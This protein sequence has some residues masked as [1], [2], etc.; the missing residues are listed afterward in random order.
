MGVIGFGDIGLEPVMAHDER[1]GAEFDARREEIER[2][3]R[4]A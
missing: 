2:V 1:A 4:L 3:A